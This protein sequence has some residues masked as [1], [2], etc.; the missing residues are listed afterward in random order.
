MQF[1]LPI[2]IL[3]VHDNEEHVSYGIS[4]SSNVVAH[5]GNVKESHLKHIMALVIV[6]MYVK[7]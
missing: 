2:D 7:Q 3:Q 1:N 5:S 4:E 6:T